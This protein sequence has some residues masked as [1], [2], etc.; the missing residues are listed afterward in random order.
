MAKGNIASLVR[1]PCLYGY[2]VK[3]GFVLVTRYIAERT[4]LNAYSLDHNVTPV[5]ANLCEDG[6][7]YIGNQVLKIGYRDEHYMTILFSLT[8]SFGII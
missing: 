7:Y 1:P 5:R 4:D 8:M 2:R 3:K 6:K